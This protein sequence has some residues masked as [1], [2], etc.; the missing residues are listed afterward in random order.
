MLTHPKSAIWKRNRWLLSLAQWTKTVAL[1]IATIPCCCLCTTLARVQEVADARVGWLSL[2]KPYKVEIL[3]KGHKWRTCPL[4]ENTVCHLRQLV[5]V[6]DR[7]PRQ[8]A[9]LFVNRFGRPISRSGIA[10]MIRRYATKAAQATPSIRG[11]RVTPHTFR[12]T[13][14]MHLLQS[15][16]EV[17]VIR[18]WLGHVSIATTNRYVEIDLAMKAK[19]L[20]ACE[21]HSENGSP[22]PWRSNNDLLTWLESL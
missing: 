19:A 21:V 14:A 8:D 1:V 22:V 17:N 6:A 10:K 18:S 2:V 9:H 16:V 5:E 15:G 20:E 4:S 12:H 11:E 3:G 7:R 13:T